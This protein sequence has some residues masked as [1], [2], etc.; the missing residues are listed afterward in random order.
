VLL[1]RGEDAA[2]RATDVAIGYTPRLLGALLVLAAGWW[3]A[4]WSRRALRR[5]MVRARVDSTVAAFVS[6]LL[7]WG[8][9][10][11][12][13]LTSLSVFGVNITA[14]AA[15][16]GAAGIT[17]GLALQGSLTNLIAGVMLLVFRPFRV[18]D[19][20]MINGQTGTVHDIELMSTRLDT[21]DNRRIIIPNNAIVTGTIEN[22]THYRIRRI[23][24]D[25]A[26]AYE[27]E[28]AG[29][30]RV[31]RRV[32]ESVA[33]AIGELPPPAQP[34]AVVLQNLGP[35]AVEWQL[36]VWVLTPQLEE[37]RQRLMEEV[38]RALAAAQIPMFYPLMY[39]PRPR[40]EA[41]AGPARGR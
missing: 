19:A 9:L 20:V 17:V 18:G 8:L 24:L 10:A 38:H 30:R 41:E 25:V 31:L 28:V 2:R 16:I 39:T 33:A 11:V 34:P 29:T 37:H 12:A 14:F 32:V 27:A 22:R 5:A 1:L 3:L 7:R 13:L 26:I 36:R 40:A 21:G 35:N 23:D 4:G 15:V 6:N